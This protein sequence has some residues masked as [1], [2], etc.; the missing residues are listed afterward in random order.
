MNICILGGTGRVGRELAARALEAGHAVTMLARDP[1]RVAL[2]D[3]RLRV[4]AGSACDPVALRAAMEGADVVLSALS[5]DGGSVL[6]ESAPLIVNAMQKAGIERII[7]IGT[8]GILNSRAEP[9]LLRYQSSESKR[10][11][12]RAAEEHHAFYRTLA[13]S[14]LAWTIVCPT[15]LPDGEYTGVYRAERDYLPEDGVRISVPDT[16]EFAFRQI[17]SMLYANA[18]VGL[19]Y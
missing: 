5:T 8:A 16:A 19:A 15:Y 2:T 7:A 9:G 13:N 17:D 14:G 4:C 11:L 10:T 18:R 3:E 6:S 12:T 1:Q